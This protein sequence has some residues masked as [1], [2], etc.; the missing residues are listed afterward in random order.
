MGWDVTRDGSVALTPKQIV[1]IQAVGRC[2]LVPP[3]YVVARKV[4]ATE[5]I[6]AY[7]EY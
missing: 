4:N 5:P 3:Q 7:G 1:G 6:Q 2:A